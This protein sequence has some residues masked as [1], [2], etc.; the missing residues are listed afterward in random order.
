[1]KSG[2]TA[3]K[4]PHKGGL[5]TNSAETNLS[6]SIDNDEIV[7][8]G[9]LPIPSEIFRLII[10]KLPTSIF[11]PLTSV[12]KSLFKQVGR[13]CLENLKLNFSYLETP[14]DQPNLIIAKYIHENN[15]FECFQ[16]MIP[17]I[18][19]DKILLALNG[20][21]A[22][23]ENEKNNDVKITLCAVLLSNDHTLE[24]SNALSNDDMLELSRQTFVYAAAIGNLKVVKYLSNEVFFLDGNTL[25]EG[26][27]HSARYG[28]EDVVQI[29]F[30]MKLIH[31]CYFESALAEAALNGHLKIVKLLL[32]YNPELR[33]IDALLNSAEKGYIDI[34]DLLLSTM[35]ENWPAGTVL[36]ISA[37][38]GHFEMVTKILDVAPI[39]EL[40]ILFEAPNA[41][42]FALSNHHKEIAEAITKYLE[43]HSDQNTPSLTPL[44]RTQLAREATKINKNDDTDAL[45]TPS[46]HAA[47]VLNQNNELNEIDEKPLTHT[48]WCTLF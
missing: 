2:A 15:K 26:L 13:Y 4:L 40:F 43:E 10:S 17:N 27:K 9:D 5:T 23:I 45:F 19:K 21:V 7:F 6:A 31:T 41:R 3:I 36:L 35:P 38:N 1:M 28:Q 47:R 48:T 46:P 29:L 12:S 34:F 24:L 14:I 25:G 33:C 44:Y 16:E 30:L 39:T 22:G 8:I 42:K 11:S 18:D 20:K 37:E 32:E